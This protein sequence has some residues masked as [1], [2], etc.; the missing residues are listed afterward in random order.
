VR[1]QPRT[2]HDLPWTRTRPARL[3]RGAILRGVFGRIIDRYALQR[4]DGAEHV[5][6]LQGPAI[7]VANHC[8][9]I[10]TPVLLRSLP[11]RRR[12]RTVVAAAADYFYTRRWLAAAVSLAFGTVPLERRRGGGAMPAD[13]PI[14]QLLGAGWS[15]VV[16]AEGTRSRDGRVGVLHSGAAVLAARHRVPI[17][18]VHISG[19]HDAMPPG[20][21]WMVR[22]PAGGRHGIDVRFGAPLRVG[23]DDEP[24]A[25]IDGVRRFMASCGAG[26]TP[27]P[28]FAAIRGA[29][30]AAA[31]EAASAQP[32]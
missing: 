15:V 18:P 9:H 23:P 28:R 12:R 11:A 19:T 21:S 17:V 7:F 27:D 3:I 2:G 29:T 1:S 24:L 30:P 8:S 22:S 20:R 32:A 14:E 4:V 16:F 26:T 6:R 10:D 5:A 25:A 31:A 13:G